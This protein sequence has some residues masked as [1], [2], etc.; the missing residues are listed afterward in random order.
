MGG[1][2][3]RLLFNLPDIRFMPRSGVQGQHNA[4]FEFDQRTQ[5]L[6]RLVIAVVDSIIHTVC[7]Q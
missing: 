2:A 6:N 3:W 7:I 4:N 5:Q 1:A